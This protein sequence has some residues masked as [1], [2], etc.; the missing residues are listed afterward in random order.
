MKLLITALLFL[1]LNSLSF[2][3]INS[4]MKQFEYRSH[5]LGTTTIPY[6]VFIPSQKEN[7]PVLLHLN[8]Q[9]LRGTISDTLF[10]LPPSFY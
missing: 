2:S 10:E 8:L 6:R 5:S 4:I 9:N 1:I 3:Q 7:R